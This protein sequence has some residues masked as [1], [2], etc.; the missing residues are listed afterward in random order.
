MRVKNDDRAINGVGRLK[1]TKSNYFGYDKIVKMLVDGG[2]DVNAKDIMGLTPLMLASIRGHKAVISHLLEGKAN[3]NMRDEEG[4]SAYVYARKNWHDDIAS[5]LI[6][7]GAKKPKKDNFLTKEEYKKGW[8]R[9]ISLGLIPKEMSNWDINPSMV[10]KLEAIG[11][12]NPL[13]W[14]PDKA[15][16]APEKTWK[17]FHQSLVHFDL[18][19]TARCFFIPENELIQFFEDIG[20]AETSSLFPEMTIK[21]AP[22]RVKLPSVLSKNAKLYGWEAKKFQVFL[23]NRQGTAVA[24]TIFIKAFGEWRIMTFRQTS[25]ISD[26]PNRQQPPE[27]PDVIVPKFERIYES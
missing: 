8:K 10:R 16:S 15:L 13:T 9:L 17:I 1:L 18:K 2:A 5:Q 4:N 20:P 7:K 6:K 26:S 11:K 27:D 12:N 22:G 24:E 14:E 23:A 21:E 19:K 3:P 25:P